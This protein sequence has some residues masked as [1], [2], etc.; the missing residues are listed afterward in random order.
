M[1]ISTK[2]TILLEIFCEFMLNSKVIFKSIKGP[3]DKELPT[4]SM[5]SRMFRL[6]SAKL[7][8]EAFCGKYWK[9]VQST[10]LEIYL[11]GT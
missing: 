9:E 10:E 6:S 3:D 1:L 8:K 2:L 4:W 5:V 11:S 7:S